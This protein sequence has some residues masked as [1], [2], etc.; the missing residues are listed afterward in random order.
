MMN[1]EEFERRLIAYLQELVRSGEIS[2]R[3]LARITGVSQPHVHN[4][5]KGKRYFSLETADEILRELH[6]DLLDLIEPE[7]L[8]EWTR[9]R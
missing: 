3:G 6:M 8:L 2:E 4:V 1:F 9:R 5:L 7:E